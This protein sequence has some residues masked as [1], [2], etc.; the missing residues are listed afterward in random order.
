MVMVGPVKLVWK[1]LSAA[2][3]SRAGIV[4]N[5]ASSGITSL[6]LPGGRTAHSRFAISLNL[7]EISIR[8][9]KKPSELVELIKKT[10]L[11]IWDEAP[12]VLF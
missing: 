3:R 6:L 1:T 9:I 8:N 10:D 12:M 11:T 7:N 4:L 2:I 5:V